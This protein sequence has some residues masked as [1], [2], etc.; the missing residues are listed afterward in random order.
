MLGT[1]LA[2]HKKRQMKVMREFYDYNES[3]IFNLKYSRD[4]LAEVYKDFPYVSRAYLGEEVIGGEEGEFIKKYI[5]GT[6]VSDAATQ[7]DY[8]TEMKA[9]LQ[10]YKARSEEGYKKYG[11][12]YFKLS[13]ALG[14]L[15][16]VLLA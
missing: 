4:K 12:M 7:L 13:V 10:I 15:L 9:R 6:G 2:E 16:A 11:V 5:S 3:L 14:I 1:A 8:L